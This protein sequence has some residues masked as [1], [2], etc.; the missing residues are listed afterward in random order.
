MY[1]EK[2]LDDIVDKNKNTCYS[3]IKMKF[4]DAKS[5]NVLTPVKAINKKEP[6]CKVGDNIRMKKTFFA[7]GC[8]ANLCEEDFVIKKLKHTVLLTYAITDLNK[9]ILLK[10]S[11]KNNCQEQIKKS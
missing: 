6:K 2:K 8:T 11:A 4:V 3:I 10:H 5:N 7:K 9:E 1:I